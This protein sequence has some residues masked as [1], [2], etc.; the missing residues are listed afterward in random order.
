MTT[1]N[2]DGRA[3]AGPRRAAGNRVARWAAGLLALIAVAGTAAC[4]GPPS[5]GDVH[6]V[7]LN[8][9]RNNVF[10]LALEPSAS[11]SPTTLV[12]SFLQALTGDQKDP[13]FSVAQE[14]LTPAARAK[15][16]PAATTTQV[17][18]Y[19]GPAL[20]TDQ[21]ADQSTDHS[22]D[23][24]AHPDAAVSSAPQAAPAAPA[25]GSVT[26]VTVKGTEVAQID[27]Y[28]FFQYVTQPVSQQFAVKYL[29]PDTGWRID[30]PP[31]F[32][33]VTPDAFKRAYQTYQSA[34]PVYLPT[35][36]GISQMDQVYLTQDTGKPDYTYD[37]LARAVLH[38]R[39]PAQ[40]THLELASTVDVDPSGV[41]RVQLKAPPAGMTDISDVQ[42]ALLQTFRDAAETQQLLSPIPLA[43]VSVTYPGCTVCHPEDVLQNSGP[44]TA[45]WVC[46]QAGQN[47]SA[48]ILSKQLTANGGP[49][50]VCPANGGKVQ[51]VVGL[52]DLQLQKNSPIAVKQ[53]TDSSDVKAPS[54]TTAVAAVEKDGSVVV[55]NDK[56]TDQ[57]VWYTASDPGN[58][59][60]LE[61]D[62][63]DGSLWVV[64]NSNL[65]HVQDPGEKGADGQNRQAVLV[66][67]GTLTRFKPSPDGLRAVVVNGQ[68]KTSNPAAAGSPLP[69]SMVTI[70]RTGSAPTLSMD[71]F[72]QLMQGPQQTGDQLSAA[73][74][75]VTD[76]AW[77]DGRTVVLLGTQTDS[78]TP[79]LY[80]V[81]LDGSQD[82]TIIDPDDAQP[83]ARHIAAATGANGG[84][85]ALWTFSDAPEPNDPSSTVTYF[86]RSGGTDSFQEIGSSPVEATVTAD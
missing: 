45:Y 72:F 23:H 34:L 65:Y 11:M 52:G 49:A 83:G 20:T 5:K 66:P 61:W 8:Q 32:R 71:T 29:G 43:E 64:D 10:I 55:V 46:P 84:H 51:S 77:A 37:A 54:G 26:N 53:T 15:W 13:T 73:L 48:A 18:N 36:G 1:G 82:S 63:V 47:A 39:Y 60:D 58:V 79:K 76:A 44:P 31:G 42:H 12:S 81:Y 3:A 30:T 57:R 41:A 27:S 62:P 56:N 40:N 67:G 19:S 69:A 28:G 4:A 16:N 14:Y 68:A 21:S 74:Q 38:G 7:T 35:H 17:V 6:G 24:S 80:K 9:S 22:A 86:K 33:W 85:A 70:D 25:V 50:G 78:T 59:T 75:N 2:P